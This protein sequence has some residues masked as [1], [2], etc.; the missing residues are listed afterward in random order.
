MSWSIHIVGKAADVKDAVQKLENFPQPLKD[1]VAL[2]ADAGTD[3]PNKA[4]A[5]VVKSSGHFD[6][7]GYGSV[8]EFTILPVTLAAPAP[9]PPTTETPP[10]AS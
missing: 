6:S 1:A 9:P 8:S 10:A 4:G 2:Y 7:A 3:N 5:L